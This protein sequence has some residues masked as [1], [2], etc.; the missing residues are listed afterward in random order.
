[1]P[2]SIGRTGKIAPTLAE[3]AAMTHTIGDARIAAIVRPVI[4]AAGI[5]LNPYHIYIGSRKRKAPISPPTTNTMVR[6]LL[7][8]SVQINARIPSTCSSS[9]YC[10]MY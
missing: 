10:R 1:M 4:S 3:T 8:I 9:L 2:K 6:K 7:V 5:S